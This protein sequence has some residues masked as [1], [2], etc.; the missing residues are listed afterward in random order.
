MSLRLDY[1][2]FTTPFA[3]NLGWDE[4]DYFFVLEGD[5]RIGVVE[6]M[7]TLLDH[8]EDNGHQVMTSE[9]TPQN[10]SPVEGFVGNQDADRA[11]NERELIPRWDFE[12]R[13]LYFGN[14]ICQG[15]QV[16]APITNSSSR[17]IPLGR[18]ARSGLESLQHRSYVEADLVDL[19]ASLDENASPIRFRVVNLRAELVSSGTK[20]L[21]SCINPVSPVSTP[22]DT[23]GP[24]AH[25]MILTQVD[26]TA[27]GAIAND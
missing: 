7:E 19:N 20:M 5:A 6:C 13:I 1:A 14:E 22:V 24:S 21:N 4:G 12:K 8:V 18:L 2:A 25:R 23:Y 16:G 9:E 15:I 11:T 27:L 3:D 17:R 10:D 26:R